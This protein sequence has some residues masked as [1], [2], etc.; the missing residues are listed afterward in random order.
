MVIK[1]FYSVF[2]SF[3]Q[4][5]VALLHEFAWHPLRVNFMVGL[6]EFFYNV[7]YSFVQYAMLTLKLTTV[8]C[9]VM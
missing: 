3:V 7:F 8:M 1:F 5:L 9:C 4:L 6:I 2:Y